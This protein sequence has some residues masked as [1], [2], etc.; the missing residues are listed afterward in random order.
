MA[1]EGEAGLAA[2]MDRFEK[3]LADLAAEVAELQRWRVARSDNPGDRKAVREKV[4]YD[5]QG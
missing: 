4:T 2:R 5:W 1:E 3:R